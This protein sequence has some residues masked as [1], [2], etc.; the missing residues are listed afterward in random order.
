MSARCFRF[1]SRRWVAGL[2][3][4][5]L[6]LFLLLPRLVA[7]EVS[8]A[9]ENDVFTHSPTPDDLYTFSIATAVDL[10]A[11]R[12][13][14]RENAF[15]DRAAGIRFDET[16]L[17]VGRELPIAG[18]WMLRAEA[19]VVRVGRGLF[20]QGT[21]N[22][23]HRWI[24]SDQVELRYL[25][26]SLHPRVALHGERWYWVAPS[27]EVAPTFAAEAVPGLRY[28]ASVGVRGRWQPASGLYLD[29]LVGVRADRV[30]LDALSRH[31][32]AGGAL[33]K[34]EVVV[35]RRVFVSWSVNE[36]GD[37]R[38]HVGLGYRFRVERGAEPH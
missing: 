15:T 20:G 30:P 38:E 7:Q 25:P 29:L 16:Y 26:T 6:G 36:Y 9:T 35:A 10:G 5:A 28:Q 31:V 11:Y 21:Q 4:P 33:A 19:G 8:F 24:G 14:L 34:L 17:G 37:E 23:V 32:D 3:A 22:A 12:I 18:S 27:L 2:L 1:V 13:G